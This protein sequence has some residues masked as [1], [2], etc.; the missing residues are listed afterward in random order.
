MLGSLQVSASFYGAADFKGDLAGVIT[1]CVINLFILVVTCTGAWRYARARILPR[2][3]GTVASW[4]PYILSSEKL[5]EDCR[6][7][8]QTC[9]DKKEQIK[10]LQQKG[11]RY[12]FGQFCNEGSMSLRLGIERNGSSALDRVEFLRP[13]K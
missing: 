3:P 5:K 2:Y 10:A 8:F 13:W 12:G 7:V 4:L 9:Q 11:R 1:T 6:D